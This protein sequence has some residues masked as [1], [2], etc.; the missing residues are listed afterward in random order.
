MT[1]LG[2]RCID[3]LRLKNSAPNTAKVYVHSVEPLDP[4]IDYLG[5]ATSARGPWI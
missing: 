2:Q 3:N 1:P 5:S 4:R